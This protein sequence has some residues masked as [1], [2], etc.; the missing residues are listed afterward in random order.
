MVVVA[1]PV[2]AS[3]VVHSTQLDISLHNNVLQRLTLVLECNLNI[4]S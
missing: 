2:A 3:N 1:V 4:I